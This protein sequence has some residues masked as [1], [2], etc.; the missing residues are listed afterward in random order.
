MWYDILQL[1]LG[2]LRYVLVLDSL[3]YKIVAQLQNLC[4]MVA[5]R[6]HLLVHV[7]QNCMKFFNTSCRSIPLFT[8]LQAFLRIHW[9]F[10]V[11]WVTWKFGHSIQYS[12]K[13]SIVL[14]FRLLKRQIHFGKVQKWQSNYV[15]EICKHLELLVRNYESR[16]IRTI[17]MYW[18]F[19]CDSFSS[20]HKYG[21]DWRMDAAK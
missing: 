21:S 7:Q 14:C 6:N 17:S 5:K 4:L 20:M 18:L 8:L 3:S 19:K 12:F 9:L 15:C 1:Q 2:I 10:V 11:D 13:V 16:N